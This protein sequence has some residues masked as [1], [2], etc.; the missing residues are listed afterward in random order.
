MKKSMLVL[1]IT[2]NMSLPVAVTVAEEEAA[3]E[4]GQEG[5]SVLVNADLMRKQKVSETLTAYGSVM[6]A[7]GATENISFARPVQVLRFLVAPG[8]VVQR[9][10][11]MLEIATDPSI[12]AAYR[13]AEAAESFARGELKR[14]EE[15]T[16]QQLATQSQVAAAR[17]AL[18]DA[19]TALEAQRVLGG[20]L[21]VQTVS[22]PYD[23]IVATQ[24][25]QQ[26][27]RVQAGTAA[28]QLAKLGALRALL[29][30]EPEDA[31]RVRVGMP[32]KLTSV[33]GA[34]KRV[35]AKITQVFGVI[36]PQTRLVDV[37]VELAA[38]QKGLLPGMQVR[39]LIQLGS[40]ESW[41]VPRSAVLRDEVSAYLYQ[42]V[43]GHAK[44]VDVAQGLESAGLVSVSGSL[45]NKLKVVTRG[46]YELKDGME[47]RES[48]R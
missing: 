23:A 32:I 7:T 28:L 26:G 14:V 42:I 33:F 38:N 29:G 34:N 44:R 22:A 10:A 8:Q 30:V 48:V 37:A 35:E 31:S 39:G 6:S 1:L 5:V 47:V 13:Q 17:R 24:S 21:N 16:S 9:G 45:D 15:L 20:G 4:G 3:A 25:V 27:D 18:V 12:T 46:N 2:V 41:V 40:Q 11:A 19:Q 36:N 43:E